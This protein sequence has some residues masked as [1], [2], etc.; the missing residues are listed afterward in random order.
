[1]K[2]EFIEIKEAKH[3]PLMNGLSLNFQAN[4][5]GHISTNC[6]IGINE[7]GKSQ[8]LETIAEIFLYVDRTYR[9]TNRVSVLEPPVLFNIGYTLVVKNKRYKVESAPKTR[10]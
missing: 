4:G 3:R 2:L 7:S 10:F 1:M 6:F 8:L 5:E 9:K